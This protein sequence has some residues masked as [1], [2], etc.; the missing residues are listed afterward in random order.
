MLNLKI[1][2]FNCFGVPLVSPKLVTRLKE[3]IKKI[4]ELE[5]DLICLQ[6]V[7][8][9]WHKQLMVKGFKDYPYFFYSQKGLLGCGGG[10]MVFSKLPLLSAKFQKF[11][12]VGNLRDL[13][14]TD[15]LVSKGFMILEVKAKINFYLINAHLTANYENLYDPARANAGI[16]KQQLNQLAAAINQLDRQQICLAGADIG[17]P[18][19][20]ELFKEFSQKTGF[21]DLTPDNV[22]THNL[23]LYYFPKLFRKVIFYK[24]D[25]YI[26]YRGPKNYTCQWQHFLDG[27]EKLSDHRGILVNLQL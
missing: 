7:F 17:V 9:P 6:E 19:D 4:K 27:S 5:S 13:T 18:P 15:R 24:K 26:L 16:Q 25:D 8:L 12:K 22:P 14:L 23:S 2:T 11:N 20:S 21:E 1:L 10:L 3:I